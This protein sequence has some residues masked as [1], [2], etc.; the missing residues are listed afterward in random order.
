MARPPISPPPQL[1]A[2]NNYLREHA[3]G[4]RP[5]RFRR[6][7]NPVSTKWSASRCS[8][9]RKLLGRSRI[10]GCTEL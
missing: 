4:C 5:R 8:A 6:K 3:L 10:P 7:H 1:R 2:D 9:P